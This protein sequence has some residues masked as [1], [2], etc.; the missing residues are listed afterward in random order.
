MHVCLDE[1]E[2]TKFEVDRINW[3]W[4]NSEDLFRI[5]V[6][7][8]HFILYKFDVSVKWGSIRCVWGFGVYL[9][10]LAR[11]IYSRDA[12]FIFLWFS[13]KWINNFFGVL[14]SEPILYWY[15]SWWRRVC[16]FDSDKGVVVDVLTSFVH[17]NFLHIGCWLTSLEIKSI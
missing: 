3:F 14:C 13:F 6:L 9:I 1:F 15:Y 17:W 10:F 2:W 16:S 11:Y 12:I 4:L 5:I 7:L 8:I